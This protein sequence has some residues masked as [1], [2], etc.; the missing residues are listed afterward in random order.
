VVYIDSGDHRAMLVDLANEAGEPVVLSSEPAPGTLELKT[1]I[2]NPTK[3]PD[4]IVET[5]PAGA[6]YIYFDLEINESGLGTPMHNLVVNQEAVAAVLPRLASPITRAAGDCPWWQ[7]AG[8]WGFL[9]T[10]RV[11]GTF[12]IGSAA[13]GV[14]PTL[15]VGTADDVAALV[16][17]PK[18]LS[19]LE[20]IIVVSGAADPLVATRLQEQATKAWGHRIPLVWGYSAAGTG[21]LDAVLYFDSEVPGNLGLPPPGAYLKL[22]PIG[23][24]FELRIK[25]AG[26][27]PL[28]LASTGLVSRAL[29]EDGFVATGE[30]VELIDPMRPYLGVR[31]V[32]RLGPQL[33]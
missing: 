28:I 22:A 8:S 20:R 2:K 6:A 12:H 9:A 32:G 13:D 16:E 30:A 18:R 31:R 27:A 4:S 24:T 7:P 17:A 29:D 25:P 21:T 10:L 14:K 11:G 33:T 3:G 19:D 1:W 5:Q 26:E 15:L 23:G